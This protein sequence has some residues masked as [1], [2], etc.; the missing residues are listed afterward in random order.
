MLPNNNLSQ[1]DAKWLLEFY[2]VKYSNG[3]RIDV[4]TIQ[5]H[6]K[7]FNLIKG[8]NQPVPNCN[9]HWVSASKVAQSLYSQYEEDIR[10]VANPP[11]TRGRKKS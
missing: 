8:T 2:G 10:A 9:C 5:Y 4:T 7:A 6:Q 1:E 11:K 3:G